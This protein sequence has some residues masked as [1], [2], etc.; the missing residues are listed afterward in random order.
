MDAERVYTLSIKVQQTGKKPR[1]KW[2][3][4]ILAELAL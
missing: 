4:H 2:Q 1:Q 3:S